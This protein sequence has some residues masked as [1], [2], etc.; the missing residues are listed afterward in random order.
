MTGVLLHTLRSLVDGEEEARRRGVNAG[1]APVLVGVVADR[2]G[3]L[4][5]FEEDLLGDGVVQAL[6]VR[7]LVL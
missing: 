7:L 1:L 3:R 6:V 5:V 4:I 2:G